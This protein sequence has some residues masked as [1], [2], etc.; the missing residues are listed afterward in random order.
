M[1]SQLSVSAMQRELVYHRPQD[2]TVRDFDIRA[3]E[4]I[5]RAGVLRRMKIYQISS[6]CSGAIYIGVPSFT[7]G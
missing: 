1:P 4:Q 7:E 5:P 3:Y 6:R 2:I